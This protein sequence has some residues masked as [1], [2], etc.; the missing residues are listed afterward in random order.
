MIFSKL[1]SRSFTA[2]VL[3]IFA[4][5][6]AF[7]QS[8]S[9]ESQVL[10]NQ[11]AEHL[12]L[13]HKISEVPENIRVQFEQNPLQLPA[14]KNDR[15]LRNFDKAYDS[16]L[17]L[18]DFKSTLA[19]KITGQYQPEISEWLNSESTQ[20][21]TDKRQEFYTLQGKRKRVITMY[22]LDQNPPSAERTD[23]IASLT[24]TMS[25]T[26]STVES[27]VIILRSIL[28]AVSQLSER[29][30]FT[31]P[32]IDGIANNF[33]SQINEQVNQELTNQSTVLFHNMKSDTLTE[34]I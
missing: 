18:N 30:T 2:L 14:E 6:P 11:L 20:V 34:Y 29:Q 10:A 4:A 33:R 9:G 28:Q 26:E 7:A 16:D 25:V 27:S 1:L 3:I 23:L 5:I 19:E 17:L 13:N 22:E 32:Q 15:M 31:N 21:I 8:L 24:D 12:A